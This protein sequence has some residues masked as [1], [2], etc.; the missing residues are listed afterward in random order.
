MKK[1]NY[2]TMSKVGAP[3]IKDPV[4]IEAQAVSV[5]VVDAGDAVVLGGAD[6]NVVEAQ[7][8]STYPLFTQEDYDNPHILVLKA[9]AYVV[10][11][12]VVLLFWILPKYI[13]K[14]IVK[15]SSIACKV[16]CNGLS[17]FC[18]M[19]CKGLEYAWKGVTSLAR[20]VY[21]NILKPT[22]DFFAFIT[23]S[24]Y[25]AIRYIVIRIYAGVCYA[26]DKLKT[27][28]LVPAWNGL[29]FIYEQI[30]LPICNAIVYIFAKTFECISY[31]CQMMYDGLCYIW[32]V[33][34]E[35][36]LM[37]LY[38][39]G[40]YCWSVLWDC[41][42]FCFN[43][44]WEGVKLVGKGM[45]WFIWYPIWWIFDKLWLGACVAKDFCFEYLALPFYNWVLVPI[46][47]LGVFM[48]NAAVNW[49]FLPIYNLVSNVLG[50]V[51]EGV[52]GILSFLYVNIVEPV[53]NVVGS[54][55]TAMGE[56]IG[57]VF[58]FISNVIES[59]LGG[60]GR[61]FKALGRMFGIK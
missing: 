12:P 37:P 40:V 53:F 1:V 15:Y 23:Y 26:W 32:N 8:E 29:C 48:K 60:L 55:F 14:K 61:M 39:F 31:V 2:D 34:K 49:I 59:V 18:E 36:I 20:L 7:I 54:I 44:L 42:S 16:F 19:T 25:S 5:C 58:N 43:M 24:V 45:Y 56:F 41:V 38:N 28:V 46:Y 11:G 10:I 35:N 51:Y 47:E 13:F 22:Y 17:W 9:V 3:D 50:V 27:Y 4:D 30:V 33:L 52:T 21:K 6:V 57:G